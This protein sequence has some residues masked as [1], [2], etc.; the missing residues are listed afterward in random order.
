LKITA[1]WWLENSENRERPQNSEKRVR[2]DWRLHMIA[3]SSIPS[4]PEQEGGFIRFLSIP[5][6]IHPGCPDKKVFLRAMAWDITVK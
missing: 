3:Y 6:F 1:I 2:K 5:V 4:C